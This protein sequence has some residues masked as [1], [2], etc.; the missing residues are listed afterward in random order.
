VAEVSATEE[1][2][3]APKPAPKP[4]RA[5]RTRAAA[6]TST[7]DASSPVEAEASAASDAAP[8]RRAQGP[9]GAEASALR[10][11]GGRG[12]E[13]SS[14][15]AA[16]SDRANGTNEGSTEMDVDAEQVG[17]EAVRFVQTLVESFGLEG[18]A[19]LR[20]DGDD[21]EVTVD[22][23]DLG[24]LVGPRGVTLLAIQDLTRV[25]AQ[26]RLGDHE[27]RLRV[28]VAGYRERR[29]EALTRFAN[30]VAAEVV[31]EGHA[32]L[33]EP[34]ASADRKVIHDVLATYSGVV[35]RSEGEDPN[36]RIVIAPAND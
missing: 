27:T 1:P 21:L 22:G 2:T 34:M 9:T 35:T 19:S 20:R 15:V 25:A 36:R 32:R 10:A 14:A 30:Q 11:R 31:T 7:E 17:Q 18:A 29:R 13:R 4:A 3:P 23:A 12:R 28:D 33:L 24:L 16:D 26:R 5:A 6:A 8:R